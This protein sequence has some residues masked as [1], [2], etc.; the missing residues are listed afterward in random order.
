MNFIPPDCLLDFR[1]FRI[2]RLNV[3]QIIN[4]FIFFWIECFGNVFSNSFAAASQK[5]NGFVASKF[6]GKVILS[7][8]QENALYL[9]ES[10]LFLVLFYFLSFF[11]LLF[12]QSDEEICFIRFIEKQG[13]S[14]FKNDSPWLLF[15]Q[16][17]EIFFF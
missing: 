8:N 16:L 13:F 7:F 17:F 14:N 2:I 3:W 9:N 15:G 4:A 1:L 11:F 10:A 5:F 6:F 12:F